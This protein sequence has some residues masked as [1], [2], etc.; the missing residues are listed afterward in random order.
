MLHRLAILLW[1][2]GICACSAPQTVFDAN[3]DLALLRSQTKEQLKQPL[4]AAQAQRNLIWLC[5][6]HADGCA[7]V[8]NAMDL[9]TQTPLDALLR[10]LALQSQADIGARAESWLLAMQLGLEYPYGDAQVTAA[11][12][13]LARLLPRDPDAVLQK[14]ALLKK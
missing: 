11:A 5:L 4:E 6:L 14:C 12:E 10:A 7:D 1:I 8:P 2:L 3:P 13:A 9:Q